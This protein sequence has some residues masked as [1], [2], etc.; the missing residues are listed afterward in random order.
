M[1]VINSL[2]EA[3]K[4]VIVLTIPIITHYYHFLK[5]SLNFE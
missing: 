5:Y 1:M 2:V 3:I 4:V